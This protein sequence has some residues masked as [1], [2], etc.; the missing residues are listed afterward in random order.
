MRLAKFKWTNKEI[1]EY[2]ENIGYW[3]DNETKKEYITNRFV[4]HYS[5]KKGTHIVPAKPNLK[6]ND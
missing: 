2:S 3:L 1:V 6:E 4:I 5:K